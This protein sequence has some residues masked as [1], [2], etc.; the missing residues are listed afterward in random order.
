MTQVLDT[1]SS[2]TTFRHSA[3][4][5]GDFCSFSY[6]NLE[7]REVEVDRLSREWCSTRESREG[8]Q[9]VQE[10]EALDEHRNHDYEEPSR[11]QQ[12]KF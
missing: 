7:R 10:E 12:T 1:L 6:R 9:A 3:H 5:Q 11:E 2:Q 8:D 4:Q